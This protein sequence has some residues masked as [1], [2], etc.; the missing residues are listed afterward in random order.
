MNVDGAYNFGDGSTSW[1][2]FAGSI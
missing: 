1:K 2:S